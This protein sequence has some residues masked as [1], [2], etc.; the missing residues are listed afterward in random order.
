MSGG[1]GQGVLQAI[2]DV[3][4]AFGVEYICKIKVVY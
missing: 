3:F 1:N 4:K 2:G